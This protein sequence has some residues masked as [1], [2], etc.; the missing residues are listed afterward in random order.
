[1]RFSQ[2]RVSGDML[3]VAW[4]DRLGVSRQSLTGHEVP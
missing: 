1:M 2:D 3:S 4:S